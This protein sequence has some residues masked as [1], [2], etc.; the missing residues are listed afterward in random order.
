[1]LQAHHS[2]TEQQSSKPQTYLCPLYFQ[3]TRKYPPVPVALPTG[4]KYVPFGIFIICFIKNVLLGAA[5]RVGTVGYQPPPREAVD[6][7]SISWVLFTGLS[8]D[9]ACLVNVEPEGTTYALNPHS[10]IEM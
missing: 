6:L 9:L 5:T 10:Q 2:H 3:S 1:M 7:N 4:N 8:V